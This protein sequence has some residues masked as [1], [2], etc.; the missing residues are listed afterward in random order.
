MKKLL[1]TL[2]IVGLSFWGVGMANADVIVGWEVTGV[3]V[4]DGTGIDS[5]SA[6]YTFSAT[7]E[8]NANV[9]GTLTLGD[10]VTASTSGSRYGFKIPSGNA[11]TTLAGSIGNNHYLQFSIVIASGFQLNLSSLEMNGETSGTTSSDDIAILSSV[12]GFSDTQVV[13]SLTGI[14]DVTGG[15]DTDS[16]GFIDPIDLTGGVYD[17]LTGTVDFRLYSYNSTGTGPTELRT[18]GGN[19]LIVNGTLVAVPEPSTGVLVMLGLGL[20]IHLRRRK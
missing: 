17:G 2:T 19:D 11:Q 12:N 18:L 9:N 5:G 13:A 8:L 16:S 10:G 7:T 1:T 6:P 4:A 14:R 20:L 3:D 15:F